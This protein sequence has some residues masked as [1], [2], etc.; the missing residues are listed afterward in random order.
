MY[1]EDYYTRAAK[2]NFSFLQNTYQLMLRFCI[3]ILIRF[4]YSAR[5]HACQRVPVILSLSRKSRRWLAI[6]CT[7]RRSRDAKNHVVTVKDR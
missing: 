7:N 6:K 5:G 2:R 3:N 1:I 4:L